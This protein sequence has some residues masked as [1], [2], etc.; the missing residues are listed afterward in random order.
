LCHRKPRCGKGCAGSP[1]AALSSR[2]DRGTTAGIEEKAAEAQNYSRK[3]HFFYSAG[4][5]VG[6]KRQTR[7][8]QGKHHLKQQQKAP[9][10]PSWG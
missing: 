1:S 10:C 9:F 7:S 8:M 2:W 5:Y 3:T 6:E 4:S